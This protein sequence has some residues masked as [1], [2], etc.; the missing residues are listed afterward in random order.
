[1]VSALRSLKP[2]WGII[3][4]FQNY[5]QLE[6]VVVHAKHWIVSL[7]KY[8][9][10]RITNTFLGIELYKI[11]KPQKVSTGSLSFCATVYPVQS[12]AYKKCFLYNSK[13]EGIR[14]LGTYTWGLIPR[15]IYRTITTRHCIPD[16]LPSLSTC[17]LYFLAFTA[18]PDHECQ[19]TCRCTICRSDHTWIEY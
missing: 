14:I 10:K 13:G 12:L 16:I 19:V 18:P 7:R 15:T 8:P 4:R 17:I 3:L 2:L 1:M 5:M 6:L 11:P 9:F